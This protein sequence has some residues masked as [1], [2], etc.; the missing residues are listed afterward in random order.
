MDNISSKSND[1]HYLFLNSHL[2]RAKNKSYIYLLL[3]VLR[4]SKCRGFKSNGN[5][6]H[7]KFDLEMRR[8]EIP[9]FS[10]NHVQKVIH[11]LV[12]AS[13]SRLKPCKLKFMKV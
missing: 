12:A 9:N 10:S 2:Y 6:T 3:R 11:S 7:S 4:K 1:N 13:Q 8:N 5:M